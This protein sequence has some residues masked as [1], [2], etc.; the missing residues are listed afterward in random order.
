MSR[1][2]RIRMPSRSAVRCAESMIGRG[3][4]P[5]YMQ[6]QSP[7][8]STVSQ[9]RKRPSRNVEPLQARAPARPS[10]SPLVISTPRS[11]GALADRLARITAAT[12][13][14]LSTA[15]TLTLPTKH[16]IPGSPAT[17]AAIWSGGQKAFRLDIPASASS[18]SARASAI[19]IPSATDP[20]IRISIGTD[21]D[22]ESRCATSQTRGF[23]RCASR[24]IDRAR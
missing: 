23:P 17:T 24:F 15:P 2:T 16:A 22:F 11:R 6:R 18:S 12:P 7:A 13:L 9:F 8:S 1:P 20:A 21:C 19:R 14:A 5:V 3:L 10:S 4:G